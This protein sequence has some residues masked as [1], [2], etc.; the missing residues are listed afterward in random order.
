MSSSNGSLIKVIKPK[1]TENFRMD[2]MLLFYISLQKC[3]LNRSCILSKIYYHTS[4]QN[5]TLSGASTAFT[6]QVRA[7]VM[8]LLILLLLF[9]LFPLGA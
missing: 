1:A 7:F 4:F 8:L 6:S 3:F 5:P 9:L 2:A